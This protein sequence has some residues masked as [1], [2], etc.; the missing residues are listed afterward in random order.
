MGDK[1]RA[2]ALAEEVGVPTVPGSP[3]EIHDA[4]EALQVARQIG[5]PVMLKAAHGGG[6]RG[7]RVVRQGAC[8]A[9]VQAAAQCTRSNT[10]WWV[11]ANAYG[12]SGVALLVQCWFHPRMYMVY[13]EIAMRLSL[14]WCHL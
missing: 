4:A 1:T 12:S 7:M 10:H 14:F 5:L 6:G 3:G 9:P 13:A 11:P 8:V 2:R